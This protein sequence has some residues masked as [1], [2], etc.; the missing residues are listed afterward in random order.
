[1]TLYITV[2]HLIFIV[3]QSEKCDNCI[4]FDGGELVVV[5]FKF[6]NLETLDLLFEVLLVLA[7]A[8]EVVPQVFG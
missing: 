3:S 5:P 1:M 8:V 4:G 6:G 2:P 7:V